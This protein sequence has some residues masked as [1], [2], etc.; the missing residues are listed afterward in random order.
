MNI[1]EARQILHN[2]GFILE[3]AHTLNKAAK[4]KDDEYT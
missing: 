3:D 2:H 1:L 4:S